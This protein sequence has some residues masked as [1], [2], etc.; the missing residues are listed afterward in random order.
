MTFVPRDKVP[1]IVDALKARGLV[2]L[3]AS[4]IVTASNCPAQ[5]GFEKIAGHREPEDFATAFGLRVHAIL[6]AYLTDGTPP[7]YDET[8]TFTPSKP[9]ETDAEKAAYARSLDRYGRPKVLYPGRTA[10][11]MMGPHLP[12]PGTATVEGA[13]VWQDP[14]IPGGF[15]VGY[16]D[17]RWLAAGGPVVLDHK[18]SVDPVRYGKTEE[19][20]RDDPQWLVYA[21]HER[22]HVPVPPAEITGVWNYGARDSSPRKARVVEVSAEPDAVRGAYERAI[23]PLANLL[24]KWRRDAPDPNA[25]PKNP[26]ACSKFRGC[27]HLGVRCNVSDADRMEALVMSDSEFSVDAL[28]SQITGGAPATPPQPVASA[29]DPVAAAMAL[30]TGGAPAALVAPV[31]PAAPPAQPPPVQGDRVN[32]PEAQAAPTPTP[33]PAPAPQAPAAPDVKFSPQDLETL[34]RI[35]GDHVAMRLAAVLGEFA[36]GG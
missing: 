13:F 19:T 34:G 17:L 21:E 35:I 33:P 20:L 15:F 23:V 22:V 27:P 6:E 8:W 18:S 11:T 28:L 32:P 30:V 26:R 3:S 36:K 9:P 31:A 7:N 24:V 4:Q 10:L 16:K 1:A 29:D 14:R 25:L 12:A 2:P 5:W